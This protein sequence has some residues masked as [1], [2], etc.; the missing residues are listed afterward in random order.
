MAYG[1]EVELVKQRVPIADVVRD[2]VGELEVRPGGDLWACCPFHHED[3]PSFHVR[4]R[5]GMF[6]C[7]GCGEGGDVI[8]FV[9]KTRGVPFR[10][11][12]E[13]LAQRAG[14]ELASLSPE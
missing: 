2:V 6:K 11:A 13:L 9:M 14:I 8:T 10:E 3:T 1:P 7:F 5:L 12:L 4:P